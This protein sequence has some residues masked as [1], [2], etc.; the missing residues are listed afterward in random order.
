MENNLEHRIR[1]RAYALWAENGY[2]DGQADQ[3]WLTAERELLAT[4][5]ADLPKAKAA[6]A[7]GSARKPR[8]RATPTPAKAM[9]RAG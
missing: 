1:D 8:S 3:H 4:L 9:A 7:K 5:T 6:A 2:I